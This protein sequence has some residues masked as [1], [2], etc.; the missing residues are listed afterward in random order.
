MMRREKSLYRL[1]FLLAAFYIVFLTP[2]MGRKH[3]YTVDATPSY[4]LTKTI[5]EE[6]RLFPA[7]AVKQG[8]VY[9][10]VYLPFYFLGDG[11]QRL[12]PGI[13][14]DWMRRKCLCWMNTVLTG[15]T[16]G[17]LSL[18]ILRLGFS[19]KA[20][21]AVPILY[22]FSTLAFAYARYDYNKCLAALL[23]LSSFYGF[24]LLRRDG[25]ISGVWMCGVSLGLLAMLRLEMMAAVPIYGI[26][27]V[28]SKKDFWRNGKKLAALAVP[29]FL[30]VVFVFVYNHFYWSGE[31]SGGYEGQFHLNPFP[32]LFGFLFSPG[33]NIWFFNPILL[34]LPLSVR[35]FREKTED[36][37]WVWLGLL[38]SLLVL[39]C[40]WGNWWGG[41]GFGPRHLVPLLPL[42]VLPLAGLVDKDDRPSWRLLMFLGALGF[43]VQILGSAIDFN[44]VIMTLMKA[45]ISEEALI[46][47]PLWNPIAQH[48]LFLKHLP[49]SRWDFGWMGL[50]QILSPITLT[51]FILVWIGG[52]G[53]IAWMGLKTKKN[54]ENGE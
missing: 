29:L 18:T 40:C 53:F 19:R 22:G 42:A 20:Q 17:L 9:S 47:N 1:P 26:G 3:G 36:V 5:V 13:E 10:I 15:A 27:L 24:L 4:K 43:V 41:W 30:G 16:V 21:I 39:Y 23:L 49:Y 37:F 28:L 34:F 14:A 45:G 32:A 12:F 31:V 38:L 46:W 35:L 48:A 25:R 2:L 54:E 51:V 50:G 52:L 8:Y 7:I 33:K 11:L 44:D 6:G